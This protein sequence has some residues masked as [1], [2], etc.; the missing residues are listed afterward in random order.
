MYIALP[1]FLNLLGSY[2]ENE[3]PVISEPGSWIVS[4]S[5]PSMFTTDI[6]PLLDNSLN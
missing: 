4:T 6:S 1:E 3:I 5:S 2:C